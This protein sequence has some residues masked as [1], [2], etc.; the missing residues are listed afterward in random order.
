MIATGIDWNLLGEA[1]LNSFVIGLG[2]L[3][4]AGV[5]VVASLRGQDARANGREGAS[6]GFGVVSAV[7]VL[8][9]AGAVVAGIWVMTQ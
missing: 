1:V 4:V 6:A 5:A 7:C 8:C 9:V 2:V 3:L